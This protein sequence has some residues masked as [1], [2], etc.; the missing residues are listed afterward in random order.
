[1]TQLLPEARA[2]DHHAFMLVAPGG[3][4]VMAR[5]LHQPRQISRAHEH[6]HDRNQHHA[7]DPFGGGELPDHQQV[8]DDAELDDEIC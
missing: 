2:L 7:A 6:A 3:F 4:G 1:M 8:E 5:L